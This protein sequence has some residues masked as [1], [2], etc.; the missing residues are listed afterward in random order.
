[1]ADGCIAEKKP[2]TENGQTTLTLML[3]CK[4]EDKEIL[5][6]F[7]DFIGV[8]KDRLTS[9]HQGKSV[10]L[11][12]AANNFTTDFS[13]FGLVPHK[14]HIENHLPNFVYENENLF[15]QYFRGLVDGDGTIHTSYGSP[16]IS[17]VGNSLSMM[18]EIKN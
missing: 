9:G 6:K 3:E 15:F 1:M 17:L 18:Q 2:H 13:D 16:G 7:C 4:T 11:S 14:S 12:I 8:R 10:A 5:E